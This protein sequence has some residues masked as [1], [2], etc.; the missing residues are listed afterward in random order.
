MRPDFPQA[1]FRDP[2]KAE[3]NWLRLEK[4]LP[5]A[6]RKP[7]GPL[8]GQSPDPDGALNLLERYTQA[9]SPDLL[10]ELGRRPSGLTYLTAAFAY[11]S[12]LAEGF[13]TEPSLVLQ[14]ARDRRFT[15]LRPR[16]GLMEDYA[17]FATTHS[18]SDLPANLGLF[19]RRNYV[20]IGLKDVLG[21][22]TLADVT[23]EL[24]E[25]ADVLLAQALLKADQEL[26]KRYGQP[27]YRDAQGRVAR[28]GFSIVSLGKLGGNELN[29]SSDIDLLFLYARDGETAGS[30]EPE[31]APA[32]SVVMNKEYFVRLA[33]SVTQRLTQATSSGP[34]FRVDLRLRPEGNAGDLVLSLGAT[35]DYYARRARDWELQ[36]LIK[37]RHSA[38]DARLTR[39]FLR[40]VESHIYRSPAH[41]EAVE[42]V[43]TSRERSSQHLRESGRETLDVKRE[44][45]GIRDVEFL[46]QCLQRLYGARD[47]WVRSGGTLHALRKLNDK[48]LLSDRDYAALTTAY[49]FL[50]KVEHRIQLDRG[51][52]SH[53]LPSE[54]EALD[55]LA[56]RMG[57]EAAGEQEPGPSLVSRVNEILES[58]REVYVRWIHPGFGDRPAAAFELKPAATGGD[59]GRHSYAA[60][61]RHLES[62]SPELARRVREAALAPRARARVAGFVTAL[63]GSADSL[64]LI[65]ESPVAVERAVKILRVS[66]YLSDLLIRHPQDLAVLANDVAQ[67]LSAAQLDMCLEPAPGMGSAAGAGSGEQVGA[68]SRAGAG[69]RPAPAFPWAVEEHLGSRE[70]MAL[71]RTGFRARVLELGARDCAQAQNVFD[72]L[73]R[74]SDL[75]ASSVAT[76]FSIALTMLQDARRCDVP[77]AVLGFGRLGLN[78]FDLGSDADLVFVAA[79]HT[80]PEERLGGMRLAEKVIEA[81]SSYT[82]DGSVF[83]VDTRLRPRGSEGEL[84]VTE[85]ALVDYAAASAHPWEAL[86]YLKACPIAGNAEVGWRVI[87]RLTDRLFEHFAGDPD[88]ARALQEMRR[89]LEKEPKGRLSPT[90]TAPGGY[91]DVDFAVS[92]LRLRHHLGVPAGSNMR[93]QIAALASAGILSDRDAETL[94][95]GGT[96]MRAVDHAARLVT[97]KSARKLFE[98]PGQAE[99][100]E[101]LLRLWGYISRDDGPLSRLHEVQQEVREVY[102]RVVA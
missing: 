62:H 82:R 70:K 59:S 7:L 16:E 63:L 102:C 29:Y 68:A 83:A 20:R 24:S 48:Q 50:R 10:R 51:Q 64:A 94:E 76:A 1:P 38:G 4:R 54:P 25:L 27:Q 60:T 44:A 95:S 85:D 47:P 30:G 72:S 97:G 2:R 73:G 19:K 84:V 57:I 40:G 23:L 100:A 75:A 15:E 52:Q 43:L 53:R 77:F 22:A 80:T 79:S 11:G 49:E 42:S 65:R 86:T 88:L 13:L 92:Y 21:L 96:F 58:V 37:A 69:P 99:G 71:L 36:M 33:Q 61:L 46:T 28:S 87:A 5:T 56:R 31:S 32:S 8:L 39:A 89:R 55:R 93:Q 34:V 9:A 14:F 41:S 6:L 67:P 101:Y 78:E 90:K 45:G 91:Y 81:L 17:R 74:W 26:G 12:L 66:E 3:E 98:R 35:L 18:A